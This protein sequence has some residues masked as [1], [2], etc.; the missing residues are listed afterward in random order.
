ML[1]VIVVRFAATTAPRTEFTICRSRTKS[2]LRKPGKINALHSGLDIHTA[3]MQAPSSTE[4][5][6]CLKNFAECNDCSADE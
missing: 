1:S 5:G 4:L 3:V 6:R 2:G